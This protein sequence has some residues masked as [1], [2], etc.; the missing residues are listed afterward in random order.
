MPKYGC[1]TLTENELNYVNALAKAGFVIEQ[2]VEQTND[3]TL[4]LTG[5]LSDWTKNRKWFR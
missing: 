3:E 1:N 4:Q 5:E 2:L